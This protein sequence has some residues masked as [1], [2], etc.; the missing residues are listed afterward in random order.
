[1]YTLSFCIGLI[2]IGVC[3]GFTSGL[4][5]VGGGFLMV[6]LQYFLLSSVGVN[7]ELAMIVS[8]A[9]SLAIIIPTSLSGA[10]KHQKVNKDIVRPGIT[11]GIFGIIGSFIG[12]QITTFL[13]VYLLQLIFAILLFG[14]AINMIHG[15]L[16]SDDKKNKDNEPKLN[17]NI[18]VAII[19]GVLVGISSGLLGVGGG[20]FIIPILTSLFGFNLTKAIGTSSVFIS[21]TAIGGFISYIISGIGANVLP[22]SLGYVSLVN[23]AL[24]V[25]ASV[26]MAT[27]GAKYA[28]K[29]PEKHLKIVFAIVIFIIAFKLLGFNPLSFIH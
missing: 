18:F 26:P 6:P 2:L 3:V 14:V 9:T 10:Y 17:F 8:I 29:V 22:Y 12:G 19:I 11:I 13:P 25:L 20:I 7:S 24:I 28:Y 27:V 21:L 1:M 4:L 15:S 5:G 16:K 23:F